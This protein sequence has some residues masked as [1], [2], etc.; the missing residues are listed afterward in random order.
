M[1]EELAQRALCEAAGHSH[2][3]SLY[4]S[5]EGTRGIIV[6]RFRVAI[7]LLNDNVFLDVFLDAKLK[8]ICFAY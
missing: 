7:V 3:W 5:V 2:R 1:Q 8:E 4:E 6:F